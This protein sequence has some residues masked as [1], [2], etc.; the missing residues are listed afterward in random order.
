MRNRWG[1]RKGSF[2]FK[3][4]IEKFYERINLSSVKTVIT[5]EQ[6]INEEKTIADIDYTEMSGIWDMDSTVQFSKKPVPAGPSGNG[7]LASGE[8]HTFTTCSTSGAFGP[9]LADAQS[10]YS[11]TAWISDAN[12][13]GVTSGIQY[14]RISPGT[15]NITTYGSVG[16]PQGYSSGTS[17]GGSG[18]QISGTYVAAQEEIWAIL[19]GQLAVPNDRRSFISNPIFNA[20]TT[21][22][23]NMFCGG[24][25]ASFVVKVSSIGSLTSPIPLVVAGGGGSTRTNSSGTYTAQSYSNATAF[26]APVT[27]GATGALVADYSSGNGGR[28][29]ITTRAGSSGAGWNTGGDAD[30]AVYYNYGSGVFSQA[31]KDGGRGATCTSFAYG[32]G[33]PVGGFGG[34]GFGGWGGSGGGGGWNGGPGAWNSAGQG[35]SGGSSYVDSSLTSVSS[36]INH[37]GEGK[38]V[39]ARVS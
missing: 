8:S 36:V 21:T 20:T 17:T 5:K 22:S 27:N 24:G 25:G 19:V 15:Y 31:L 1:G 9:S 38:I 12:K 3:H 14:V 29:S 13:F 2:N 4:F 11:G 10:A 6:F 7:F 26:T 35:G 39:I 32:S 28:A 33:L 30:Q 34:G 16:T 18:A 37:R 23:M